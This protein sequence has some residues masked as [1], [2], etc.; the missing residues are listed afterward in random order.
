[1]HQQPVG[2]REGVAPALGLV[3]GEHDGDEGEQIDEE[4]QL[5]DADLAGEAFGDGIADGVDREGEKSEENAD[6]HGGSPGG[7]PRL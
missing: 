1:M 3:L 2:E 6:R 4:L 7:M 5:E